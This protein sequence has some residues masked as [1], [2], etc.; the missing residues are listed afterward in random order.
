M[1]ITYPLS[2]P[3][4]G[5]TSV[6]FQPRNATVVSKSPFTYQGQVQ[7]WTGQ[8][9]TAQVT[10]EDLM[11]EQAELWV[12]FLY[13]LKGHVGTFL[14]GDP[15]QVSTLGVGGGTPR[16]N[17]GGQTGNTV[18]CDGAPASVT[19]YLKAGDWIQFGGATTQSRF[20]KVL[21]NV[22]SDAGGNFTL[23]LWPNLRVILVD[24]LLVRTGTLAQGLFRLSGDFSYTEDNFNKYSIEFSCEEVI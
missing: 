21:A 6:T 16:V 24:D 23:D 19:N 14:M 13:S 2:I 20:H 4:V 22:D 9:L 3:T 11:R 18:I 7:A 8:Q 12:S 15:M 17:G 1:P 10:V 5:V